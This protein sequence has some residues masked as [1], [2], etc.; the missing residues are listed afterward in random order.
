MSFELRR[1]RIGLY[2]KT[3]TGHHS[4][5]D[6]R[7]PDDPNDTTFD[8]HPTDYPVVEVDYPAEDAKER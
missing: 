2:Y 3:L 4:P 7:N 8:P 6:F 5:T 1:W